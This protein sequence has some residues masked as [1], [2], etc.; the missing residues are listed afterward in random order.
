MVLIM[1]KMITYRYF[2]SS[3]VSKFIIDSTDENLSIN[4]GWVSSTDAYHMNIQYSMFK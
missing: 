2:V 3:N 4:Y 1:N